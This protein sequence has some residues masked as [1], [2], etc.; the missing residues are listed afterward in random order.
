MPIEEKTY[1]S[2]TILAILSF[3]I[4]V[5]IFRYSLYLDGMPIIFAMFSMLRFVCWGL[6][7]MMYFSRPK[8]IDSIG[9][10]L[11]SYG[12]FVFAISLLKDSDS[13]YSIVSIG[14]DIFI[15]WGIFNIYYERY[16]EWMLKIIIF[17]FSTCIYANA[18]LLLLYPNGIWTTANGTN[19]FFLGGNYNQMGGVILPALTIHA[20][21]T[22]LY[23]KGK[24]HLWILTIASLFSILD[25][26]SKTS[27]I[28]IFLLL[29]IYFIKSYNIRK[30][31]LRVFFYF[32]L[33]FQALI[34][35][36]HTDLESY[37]IITYFIEDVLEKDLTFT[38]RTEVWLMT[39]DLIHDSPIV[40]HGYLSPDW[41]EDNLSVRSTHNWILYIL[42]CGGIVGIAIIIGLFSNVLW[43]Y[44]KNS[45]PFSPQI[46][47]AGL[48]ILFFM[49]T[50]EIYPFIFV[51]LLM[52]L[53]YYHH[54]INVGPESINNIQ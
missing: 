27:V 50:M 47:M 51:V 7:F 48:L 41:Y 20:Y 54:D 2:R 53:I 49:M 14:M 1:Y 10:W 46:V 16:S 25:V 31:V 43:R 24:L 40:G 42:I 34:V 17:A 12:A 35:F 13:P 30:W 33:I 29:F 8:K 18:I 45:K 23:K 21:Y 32:Y 19:Y 4:C 52:F 9:F 39:F 36:L 5:I 44:Y 11:L 26:G 3:L 38:N 6:F 15:L 37:P 22:T 28:G